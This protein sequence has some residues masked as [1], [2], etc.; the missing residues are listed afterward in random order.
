MKTAT[1]RCEHVAA[2]IHLDISEEDICYIQCGLIQIRLNPAQATKVSNHCPCMPAQMWFEQL[3]GLSG[4]SMTI[5]PS[6]LDLKG[7]YVSIWPVG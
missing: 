3:N 6:Q 4:A 7:E 5:D 2:D 1:I